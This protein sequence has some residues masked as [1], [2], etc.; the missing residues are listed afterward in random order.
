MEY[1]K[2]FALFVATAIAEIVGC[3]LPYLWLQH[4]RSAWLL[5]GC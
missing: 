5:A 3:Y 4:G 1:T 2:V